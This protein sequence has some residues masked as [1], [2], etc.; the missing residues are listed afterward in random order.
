M[1]DDSDEDSSEL[2]EAPT[3]PP[4]N[5]G[6]RA[7]GETASD[8]TS[9]RGILVTD[10][11]PRKRGSV[12]RFSVVAEEVEFLV[13]SPS[14][15]TS[16]KASSPETSPL[17]CPS[18]GG[19]PASLAIDVQD[20]GGGRRQ[21][22]SEDFLDDLQGLR[23]TVMPQLGRLESLVQDLASARAQAAWA[24][25]GIING[26]QAARD[27]GDQLKSEL[28]RLEKADR[29]QD[30][31]TQLLERLKGMSHEG[32]VSAFH[33]MD[34]NG[35]GTLDK[36]EVEAACKTA[37]LTIQPLQLIML[38]KKFDADRRGQIS[39]ENFLA[40]IKAS[41]AADECARLQATLK[42]AECEQ[43]AVLAEMQLRCTSAEL[44]LRALR[45]EQ[46]L[47]AARCC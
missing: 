4:S 14:N 13:H 5:A 32:L 3:L 35:S 30:T 24:R 29:E 33:A 17:P 1:S 25:N 2:P 45:A 34:T 46:E 15:S 41:T 16:S 12:V 43:R 42:L 40:E 27:K 39:I 18:S 20:E 28:H 21:A 37:G 19:P 10:G 26:L 6:G 38:M 8:S 11:S 9:P 22:S 7:A 44:E 23:R 31:L 47:N 36:L